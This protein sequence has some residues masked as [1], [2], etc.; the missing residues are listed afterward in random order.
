[1]ARVSGARAGEDEGLAGGANGEVG[2]DGE[3]CRGA[4]GDVKLPVLQ[5]GGEHQ[6]AFH[7]GEAVADAEARAA[8]E[9]EIGEFGPCGLGFGGEPVGIE[10]ER[11][12]PPA[13]VMVDNKLGEDEVRAF[14]NEVAAAHGVGLFGGAGDDPGGRVETHGF[15]E[16]LL[17]VHEAGTIV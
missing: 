8:A 16:D 1:M 14:G 2:G 11:V 9:G 12:G 13:G 10:A 3:L 4:G 15:S 17:C 5:D 6:D 7:P